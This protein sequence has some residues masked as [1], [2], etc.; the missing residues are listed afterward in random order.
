MGKNNPRSYNCKDEELPVVAQYVAFGFERDLA[1]FTAFSPKFDAAYATQF[2]DRIAACRQLVAPETE[3]A[4]LKQITT[5]L[6][7]LMQSIL[8]P[9]RHLDGYLKLAKNDLPLSAADFGIKALRSGLRSK[10]TEKVLDA[11]QL[12]NTNLDRFSSQ[13]TPVG[14]TEEITGFFD[15]TG[16]N[17]NQL[18]QQQY[19]ILSNRRMLIEEN[20]E[21]MNQ[22]YGQIQEILSIGKILYTDVDPGRLQEYTFSKLM[23][24]VRQTSGK[25]TTATKSAPQA[26]YEDPVPGE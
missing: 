18:N 4:E 1:D 12:I 20:V 25:E 3:S 21:I 14:L 8:M 24:Q 22:L 13:L 15:T 9:L 23:K 2:T 5:E 16:E 6:Y 17:L 19:Q 11:L 7:A 10:D 26:S